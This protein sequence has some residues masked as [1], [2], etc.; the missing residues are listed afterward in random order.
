ML[1]RSD[2]DDET[3]QQFSLIIA[4][5]ADEARNVVS[6][7]K[8]L[9]IIEPSHPRRISAALGSRLALELDESGYRYMN[10]KWVEALKH[11]VG[12]E[13]VVLGEVENAILPTLTEGDFAYLQNII[14]NASSIPW[15]TASGSLTAGMV[16]LRPRPQ[17][18]E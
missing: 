11:D 5:V 17:C 3:I 2:I 15:V 7:G 13:F 18:P 12:D 10:Q 4:R 8:A 9:T 6:P 14:A 16:G 1:I